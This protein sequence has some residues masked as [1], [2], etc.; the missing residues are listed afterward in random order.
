MRSDA[1]EHR[2]SGSI[3][4]THR[5]L[6]T[7]TDTGVGKTLISAGLCAW[8]TQRGER[9]IGFKPVES[10]T[11]ENA[12]DPADTVLLARCS[13][14]EPGLCNVYALPE[15]LAPVLAARRAGVEIEPGMLDAG[16][17]RATETA[18][19]VIVE[20][21]GGALVEVT[22][23]VM[24]ADLA[25]QWELQTVVVAANRLGVLSHTLLTVEALQRRGVPV[26]GVVLNTV[27]SGRAGLAEETNRAEL[28]RLL[29]ES[30]PLLGVCPFVALED[31]VKPGILAASVAQV[32]ERLFDGGELL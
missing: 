1:R 20:G 3:A 7:G 5:L 13:G 26:L 21:V 24:V 4:V 31:R 32:A 11:D 9:V 12:G 30:V 14:V 18:E 8:L 28:E 19:H 25:S 10:G 2:V 27:Q 17:A 15:P 16:L 22:P 23:G 29:P 6:V